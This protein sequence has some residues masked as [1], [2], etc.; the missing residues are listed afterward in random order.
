MESETKIM[1]KKIFDKNLFF[2]IFT[3]PEMTKIRNEKNKNTKK[4][5]EKNI[6]SKIIFLWNYVFFQVSF[7]LQKKSE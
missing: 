3:S 5:L 6:K 4:K 1:T 2:G 7:T